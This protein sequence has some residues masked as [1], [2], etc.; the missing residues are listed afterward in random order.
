MYLVM[1][2]KSLLIQ[3][4]VPSLG[5]L[6]KESG[7]LPLDTCKVAIRRA[8]DLLKRQIQPSTHDDQEPL[9]HKHEALLQCMD[10]LLL[11]L[12]QVL[13]MSDSDI[14]EI[15]KD[16]VCDIVDPYLYFVA[17]QS[18]KDLTPSFKTLWSILSLLLKNSRSLT[19]CGP[20]ILQIFI[21]LFDEVCKGH[22]STSYDD[23]FPVSP[24]VVITVLAQSL[25]R[26]DPTEIERN[27]LSLSVLFDGVL[28]V[29]KRADLQTCYLIT[30]SLLP[31]L[32]N[33][34]N[35]QRRACQVWDFIM[36]VHRQ[37]V[38]VTSLGSD[39]ILALLCCLSDVFLSF[40]ESS[41]FSSLSS[42][43]ADNR[44]PVCDLRK[45]DQF[46][47]IVQENLVSYDPFARKRARYLVH[48]VLESV[49]SK[50][51]EEGEPIVSDTR[52][53]WWSA[54]SNED[55]GNLW[56]DLMLVLETMEEKQVCT[57]ICV[58]VYEYLSLF[59]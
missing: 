58:C 43:T 7:V 18:S 29:L 32:F 38:C 49:R 19:A 41:P 23:P 36:D 34:Q 15:A 16:V 1:M 17:T 39:L 52:V 21:D 53:F 20:H 28:S 13:A 12:P 42:L 30:S 4:S 3:T 2:S 40:N 9:L 35:A 44:G 46:W 31:L 25:S 6:L 48:L 33:A 55:L 14:L 10:T 11:L 5:E 37:V 57:H 50:G 47:E 8:S 27:G 45:E 51:A 22:S 54:E 56:D 24:N 59:L 26:A